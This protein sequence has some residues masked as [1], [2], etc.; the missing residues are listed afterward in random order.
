MK[1]REKI[2]QLVQDWMKSHEEDTFVKNQYGNYIYSSGASSI[3]LVCFFEHI[4][5]DY[6]DENQN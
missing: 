6:L 2:K 3:N 5:E 1:D 4:L